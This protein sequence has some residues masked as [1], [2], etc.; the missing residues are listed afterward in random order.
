MHLRFGQ[1]NNVDGAFHNSSMYSRLVQYLRQAMEAWEKIRVMHDYRTPSA[2]RSFALIWLLLSSMLLSPLFAKYSKDYGYMSGIYAAIVVSLL[3][4]GLHQILQNEEDPF[5]GA[6]IDDLSL[7]PLS[8]MTQYMYDKPKTVRTRV[9]VMEKKKKNAT[10]WRKGKSQPAL[11][12][13]KKLSGGKKT[14]TEEDAEL[15][16]EL[17]PNSGRRQPGENYV[18]KFVDQKIMDR[19]RTQ[20]PMLTNKD[21]RAQFMFYGEEE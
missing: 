1:L 18:T 16:E 2:L 15:E 8:L 10:V 14:E 3:L 17:A 21:Q 4:S 12:P 20:N 9:H 13:F 11:K 19:L 6:G 5:D 7:D